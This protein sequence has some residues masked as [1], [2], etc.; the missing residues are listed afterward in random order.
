MQSKSNHY[1]HTMLC[2]KKIMVFDILDMKMHSYNYQVGSEVTEA[3]S[4]QW[5]VIHEI[6]F[7][8]VTELN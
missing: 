5:P 3:L 1:T 6:M 7:T 2:L 8:Q 4:I